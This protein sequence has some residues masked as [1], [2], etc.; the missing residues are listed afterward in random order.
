M[1]APTISSAEIANRARERADMVNS[2]FCSDAEVTRYCEKAWQEFYGI[3]TAKEPDLCVTKASS[4]LTTV[5]GTAS[6]SLASDVKAPRRFRIQNGASLRR[7]E[8]PTFEAFDYG[9]RTGKPSHYWL[10]GAAAAVLKV[11]L[12]PTPGGVYTIDYWYIPSLSLADVTAPGMNFIAG[13]DE[14]VV[15]TAAMKMK[16]K[17]ESDV[18]VVVGERKALLENIIA[19][20]QS[21][22]T[23]EPT[24]MTAF[25]MGPFDIE[26]RVWGG[27]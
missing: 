25:G 12:L 20:L 19:N 27:G 9:G 2:D 8:L 4:A 3:I 26:E 6:Y 18:S 7:A 16:D 23:G 22:D 13:W 17:E 1:A 10:T 14:Y 11:T 15:L 24:T 5:S 21:F